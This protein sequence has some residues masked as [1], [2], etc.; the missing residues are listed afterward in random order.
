MKPESK[1]DIDPFEEIMEHL[2]EK[3]GIDLDTHFTVQGSE[4]P[5]K[6]VQR[7]C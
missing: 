6:Q 7:S 5:G 4:R 3:R 1:E 2:K